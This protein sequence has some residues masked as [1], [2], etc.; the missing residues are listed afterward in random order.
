MKNNTFFLSA[1]FVLYAILSEGCDCN[2]CGP[3]NEDSKLVILVELPKYSA[4]L[5]LYDFYP[6][7]QIVGF[8]IPPCCLFT[9]DIREHGE[10]YIELVV[11]GECYDG[12]FSKSFKGAASEGVLGT[13]CP[14]YLLG[15]GCF[16]DG[17]ASSSIEVEATG[18]LNVLKLCVTIPWSQYHGRIDFNISLTYRTMCTQGDSGCSSCGENKYYYGYY[19][20]EGV[21]TYYR[22]EGGVL[23][24]CVP[25]PNPNAPIYY[26]NETDYP[27]HFFDCVSSQ[28]CKP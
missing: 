2:K 18:I 26:I 15:G 3:G 19:R 20:H 7:N 22:P 12:E 28:N 11:S 21:L 5:C 24:E 4:D 25:N 17:G 14:N 16:Y 1:L 8:N 27:Y 10:H 23:L 13:N 9:R 6:Y